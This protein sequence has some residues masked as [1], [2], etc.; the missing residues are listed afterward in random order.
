MLCE[1]GVS[2]T[3]PQPDPEDQVPVAGETMEVPQAAI[4]WRSGAG[5][6]PHA[7]W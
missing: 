4:P 7:L 2:L 5:R 1:S 3:A 6:L